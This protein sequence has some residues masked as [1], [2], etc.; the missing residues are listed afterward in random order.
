MK[1]YSLAIPNVLCVMQADEAS[2]RA[3]GLQ[4][5]LDVM[6]TSLDQ[7]SRQALRAAVALEKSCGGFPGDSRAE[8]ATLLAQLKRSLSQL[9]VLSIGER[10]ESNPGPLE[11]NSLENANCFPLIH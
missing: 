8:V 6:Q 5:T 4:A 2:H 7:H 1:L 9:L 10:R 3:R 11:G